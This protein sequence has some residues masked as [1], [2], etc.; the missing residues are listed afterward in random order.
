MGIYPLPHN[1]SL[2]VLADCPSLHILGRRLG[3]HLLPVTLTL[4]LL[5]FV[6]YSFASIFQVVYTISCE[7]A[8]KSDL[9][10]S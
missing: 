1:P 7:L 6:I 8:V 5:S 4:D 2:P 9:V 10:A 3:K